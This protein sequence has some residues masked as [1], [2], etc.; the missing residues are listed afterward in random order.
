MEK[1]NVN[2]EKNKMIIP[3]PRV[4]PTNIG[5]VKNIKKDILKN[6]K[7]T[8]IY[9]WLKPNSKDETHSFWMIPTEITDGEIYGYCFNGHDWD[10]YVFL[11]EDL[12]SFY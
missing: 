11:L 7:N 6:C 9:V 4:M 5:D 1:N 2:K 8:Y 10:Y 12:Q 3:I